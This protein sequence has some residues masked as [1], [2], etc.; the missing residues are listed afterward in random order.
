MYI[1]TLTLIFFSFFFFFWLSHAA[2]RIL[3]LRPG[4]EPLLLEMKAWRPN[5]WTARE[6][7]FILVKWNL[8]DFAGWWM[9]PYL[10]SGSN[11]WLIRA[12]TTY[13]L[14]DHQLRCQRRWWSEC[15]SLRITH[16]RSRPVGVLTPGRVFGVIPLL[17]VTYLGHWHYHIPEWEVLILPVSPSF[18]SQTLVNRKMLKASWDDWHWLSFYSALINVVLTYWLDACV[19]AFVCE[20]NCWLDFC[21]SSY[22]QLEY[23]FS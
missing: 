5:Y 23:I 6:V 17:V 9:M 16:E 13:G 22:L 21:L 4:I 12:D 3:V 14:W 7:P 19:C 15:L 10:S 11:V 1:I 2:C 20:C 18:I 8:S